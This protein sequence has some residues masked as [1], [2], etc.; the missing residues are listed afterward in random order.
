MTSE[1]RET[2]LFWEDFKRFYPVKALALLVIVALTTVS[3]GKE[4][5]LAIAIKDLN[6]D[7]LPAKAPRPTKPA[8]KLHAAVTQLKA[9]L[10]KQATGSL[11]E[12]QAKQARAARAETAQQLSSVARQFA[13]DRK[14]LADLHAKD[15]LSRLAVIEK[16]TAEIKQDLITALAAVPKSGDKSSAAKSA[17]K[18]LTALSP[19]KPQQPLS[20]DLSFGIKNAKPRSVSLSAGITPAYQAPSPESEPSSLPREAQPAD[21]EETDETKVTPALTQLATELDRDPVKIYEY[22]KNNILFEPYYGIR[23]GADQTLA[24]KAGSDADQ[25]ALLIA[26]L[27]IS[28]IHARFVQGV[29]ELSAAKA[30]NWLG[31]DVANGER[32]D[33]VP[34]IL[35]SGGIPTSP[36]RANGRLTKVRFSH[37]W[38]EAYV[39][40]EAYR[41]VDEGVGSKRWV[42]LDGSVKATEFKR[43]EADFKEL[44][45]PALTDW[46]QTFV[47]GSQAVGDV[48]IIAPP[49]AQTA[50]ATAQ[51]L[52]DAKSVLEDH[53]IDDDSTLSDVIGS[54]LVKQE[55]ATYLPGSTPFKPSSVTGELRALPDQ[56]KSSVSIEVSGSDPLS[57]PS[58]S[59]DPED[60]ATGFSYAQTTNNLAN[61]RIT[62][63]YVPATE[64]DAEIVDAYHGL[65]NAPSYAASLI[66]VLRVDGRVVGRGRAPVSTGYTQNF[67]IAYRMPGF[68][69]DVVENPIDIGSL[70][71]LSIDLGAPTGDRLEAR[72][73]ALSE[74]AETTTKENVLTDVRAGEM[75]SQLG[76][77][78]FLSNDTFETLLDRA[79]GVR[80]Q[81]Q[82]SGAIT[83]T[84]LGVARVASFPVATSLDGISIDVDQ[85][86]RTAIAATGST[87]A[88]QSY[89][90]A[91][92]AN[93][94]QTEGEIFAPVLAPSVSTIGLFKE[95]VQQQIPFYRI[96]AAN[97]ETQLSTIQVPF[98]VKQEIRAATQAPGVSVVIPARTITVGGWSGVG[99]VVETNGASDY[100]IFGGT[101][102]GYAGL[103]PGDPGQAIA[104]S[105]NPYAD[106]VRD[107]ASAAH[108]ECKLGS[109]ITMTVVA[110]IA[111]L[112]LAVIIS[113]LP[114]AGIVAIEGVAMMLNMWL[115]A[116]VMTGILWRDCLDGK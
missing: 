75:L 15:A 2:K 95:A 28:G 42:A 21:L 103:A 109:A 82:L 10:E 61:K 14:K 110:L 48:G 30:A 96:N 27:R 77:L 100:R 88:A 64:N 4:A 23:K 13:S 51:M 98:E 52:D 8:E 31:V 56:L 16:K 67:R 43:P 74:T 12:K 116:W 78:Y 115:F 104:D 44:L 106:Y 6:Y 7:S 35:W 113:H 76:S 3:C 19:D 17:I 60:D 25:A 22:V 47:D 40:G 65:L 92:G 63:A 87:D 84:A 72:A 81:R 90:R 71:A 41:G 49:P 57:M 70:S 36:V 54:R 83:A 39:A 24:E 102:G 46:T 5:S 37:F 79:S 18:Q 34:E 1:D 91:A 62:V 93:A 20:S 97:A 68:A 45:T 101:S 111:S 59:E 94:S 29:A 108:T 26:L 112:L 33:A 89:A 32:M 86:V 53:G 85:D 105:I 69:A 9:L 11:T 114:A 73:E 99:Y 55:N 58:A 38:V 80:H 66:P 107:Q 50:A